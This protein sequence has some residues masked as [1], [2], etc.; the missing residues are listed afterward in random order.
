MKRR[1]TFGVVISMLALLAGC[2]W[3]SFHCLLYQ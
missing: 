1:I 2:G 3:R